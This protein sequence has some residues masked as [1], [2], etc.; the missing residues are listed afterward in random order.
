[1]LVIEG[2]IAVDTFFF[3]GVLGR[4]PRREGRRSA[5]GSSVLGMLAG[6]YARVTPAFAATLVFYSQI[7]S[8]VGD[9]PFFVRFQRSVFRGA[10]GVVDG[11]ALPAQFRSLRQRRGL[12][13]VVVVP[14]CDMSSSRA[15]PR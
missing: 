2:E 14:G 1:M 7:A 15:R 13:G 8:R 3:L 11:A 4:V 6:R 10:T 9:G 5:R 12:H